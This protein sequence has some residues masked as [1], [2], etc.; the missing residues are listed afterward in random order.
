MRILAA[1]QTVTAV[2][3]GA[4][5]LNIDIDQADTELLKLALIVIGLNRHCCRTR[6]P[7]D[8]RRQSGRLSV[9]A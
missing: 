4:V 8:S 9:L 6:L 7:E 3:L 1:L 5:E 2:Q